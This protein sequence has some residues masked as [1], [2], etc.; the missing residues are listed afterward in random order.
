MKKKK[1]CP[2][3][4][5]EFNLLLFIFILFSQLLAVLLQQTHKGAQTE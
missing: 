5:R 3:T 4:G 2:L 1:N